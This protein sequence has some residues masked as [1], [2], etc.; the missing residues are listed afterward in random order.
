MLDKQT[1]SKVKSEPLFSLNKRILLINTTVP[2]FLNKQLNSIEAVNSPHCE[3][4]DNFFGDLI[5][6]NYSHP[7]MD[8]YNKLF[9]LFKYLLKLIISLLF[10]LIVS[11]M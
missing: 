8:H 1:I 7:G 4:S 11:R 10:M 6:K 2:L 9:Y 5:S 3:K